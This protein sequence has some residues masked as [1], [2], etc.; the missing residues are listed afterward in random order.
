LAFTTLQLN[1]AP[2]SERLVVHIAASLPN[3]HTLTLDRISRS[4]LHSPD[5]AYAYPPIPRVVNDNDVPP[6]PLLG[7]QLNLP[8]LLLLPSLKNLSIRE[9]HLGDPQWEE[10]G[11][12]IACKLERLDLGGSYH[13][14]DDRNGAALLRILKAAGPSIAHLSLSTPLPPPSST[15]LSSPSSEMGGSSSVPPSPSSG[16]SSGSGA[17]TFP[18]VP[19]RNTSPTPTPTLGNLKILHTSPYFPIEHLTETLAHFEGSPIHT[20]SVECFDIDAVDASWAL[21]DFLSVRVCRRGEEEEEGARLGRRSEG[22]KEEFFDCYDRLKRVEV[23]VIARPEDDATTTGGSLWKQKQEQMVVCGVR[24][25]VGYCRDLGL[26]AVVRRRVS[27]EGE[28]EEWDLGEEERGEDECC[29]DV[30]AI[31]P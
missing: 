7:D 17:F 4:T 1:R 10:T 13:E 25:W 22:D 31:I 14:S 8:S 30:E 21:E 15:R 6:H 19:T 27:E 12:R 23:V 28:E 29:W 16:S 18:P 3:L 20:L 9:T 24:R 11:Q 5:I 26:S 2:R